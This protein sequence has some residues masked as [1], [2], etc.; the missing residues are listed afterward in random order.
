LFAD[1]SACEICGRADFLLSLLVHTCRRSPL[2]PRQAETMQLIRRSVG[3]IEPGGAS[4][5]EL[6]R[7]CPDGRDQDDASHEA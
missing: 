5:I 7:L 4:L 1:G 2:T 6:L 3:A